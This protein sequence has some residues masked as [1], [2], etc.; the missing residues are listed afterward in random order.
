[1]T[2]RYVR[3]TFAEA[4]YRDEH[5]EPFTYGDR[6]GVA[7]PPEDTYSR[8]AH[9]ERFAPLHDVA[10]A[11]VAHLVATYD[12][13]VLEGDEALVDLHLDAQPVRRAV[14]LVPAAADAAP[15]TLAWTG[16]PGVVVR[17]GVLFEGA[18]PIC[19]CD[20]C[21]ETAGSVAQQVEEL[22]LG[23]V[24]GRLQETLD[25]RRTGR[26]LTT[27]DGGWSSEAGE[28]PRWATDE[29]LRAAARRLADLPDGWRPWPVRVA[30][31]EV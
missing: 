20:A 6:W 31:P 18:L 21:D 9:P 27:P 2:A 11:L 14:R 13:E 24:D 4:T 1:M 30:T 26:R 15:L 12:V 28:A 3:P 8:D 5:G 7:G 19:G 29:H 25:G 16:Y 17:A 22:V 23:V 10:D